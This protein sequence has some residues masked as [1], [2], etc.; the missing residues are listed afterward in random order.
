MSNSKGGFNMADN[1]LPSFIKE[2]QDKLIFNGG[3]NKEFLAYVPEK[4]FERNVAEVNGEYI[5]IMGIFDYTVEDSETGKNIGL[6]PFRFPTMFTTKPYRVDKVKGIQLIKTM[7]PSD[8]RILRYQDGDEIAVSTSVVQSVANAEKF[9][10][11]WFILGYIINTIPYDKLYEYMV[12]NLAL[13]GSSYGLNAQMLGVPFSELCRS[14]DDI[15]IPFRLSKSKDMNNY[16]SVSVKQVS[17]L[18]SPY[19]ALISEDFDESVLYAMMNDTPKDTPLEKILV[20][21]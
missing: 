15:K 13:N 6:Y 21:D 14:K 20:G 4:Y 16:K 1:G 8:Y 11:L 17:K 9:M 5:E 10:N 3:K 2:E 7:E 12:D 18:L 19:T